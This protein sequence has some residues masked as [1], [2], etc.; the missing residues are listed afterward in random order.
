MPTR[1]VPEI[2]LL[3]QAKQLMWGSCFFFLLLAWFAKFLECS[4]GAG[5]LLAGTHTELLV[6]RYQRQLQ[7]HLVL[8]NKSFSSRRQGLLMVMAVFFFFDNTWSWPLFTSLTVWRD[9]KSR[10]VSRLVR[11]VC[12]VCCR[13]ASSRYVVALDWMDPHT[14]IHDDSS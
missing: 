5:G 13:L 3:Y 7:Q 12:G 9:R 10:L 1:T 14:R 11:H 8:S 4:A 6:K 2:N